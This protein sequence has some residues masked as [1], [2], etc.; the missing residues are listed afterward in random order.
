M[1]GLGVIARV[2]W[3]YLMTLT[4]FNH[5]EVCIPT[6]LVDLIFSYFVKA[7]VHSCSIVKKLLTLNYTKLVFIQKST[8][9]S[10]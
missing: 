1:D 4:Y 3:S 10:V 6:G 8:N 7:G 2:N 9:N 5:S